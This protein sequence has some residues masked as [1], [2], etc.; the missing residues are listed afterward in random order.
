[1]FNKYEQLT[2]YGRLCAQ[3]SVERFS[4]EYDWTAKPSQCC[5]RIPGI[6]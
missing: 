5:K 1:M 4:F 2:R 6:R 3:E